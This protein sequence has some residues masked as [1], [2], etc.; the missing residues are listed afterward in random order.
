MPAK[1]ASGNGAGEPA[2]IGLALAGGGP[3]GA[4]YE[5]GAL[6]ALEECLEGVALNDLDIYVGVSAGAFVA[7]CL[8]NGITAT[9]LCR[10]IVSEH[11]ERVLF[12]P[13]KFFTPAL[14]E[15]RRR[16]AMV[17]G[18]LFDGLLD[19]LREPRNY[20][21]FEPLLRLA[22]ALPVG[23]FETRPV[24]EFLHKL[25]SRA[26]RTDDFR[27]LPKPLIIVAAELDTGQPVRFGEAGWDHVPVSQAVQ[28]SAALPGLYPPVE[29][30]GR[31]YVDGVLRKTMHAS[32]ALEAGVDLLLAIN[33]IV[34]LDVSG[35]TGGGS[36]K[37]LERGLPAVM[38][39]SLRTLIR[40]RMDVG[41]KMYDSQ[42]PTAQVLLIEPRRD[43]HRMFFT[44]VFSFSERK[45][46]CEHAYSSTRAYLREHAGE[47]APKLALH[48]VRLRAEVLAD[49]ERTLWR[50]LKRRSRRRQ[51]G[52]GLAVIDRLEGALD[53]LEELLPAN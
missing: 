35:R 8:A 11:S 14:G 26:G 39:Q 7:A 4:V 47:L 40:S 36:S 51:G 16:A 22:R 21:A 6:R 19:Y 18:L 42:F 52:T 44:N 45:A 13:A 1:S 41:M 3:A 25:F 5:I 33:P 48:G 28:A 38:A 32:V 29:I 31:L 27:E 23:V 50:G 20:S 24:G 34:P 53:R 9:E 37:L 12:D 49:E 2:R 15:F 43:D 17:P 10:A 30:D 46:V